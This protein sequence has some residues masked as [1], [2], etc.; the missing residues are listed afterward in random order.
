M[1]LG[2]TQDD[3][4]EL[5]RDLDIRAKKEAAEKEMEEIIKI[6]GADAIGTTFSDPEIMK[7]PENRFTFDDQ[8]KATFDVI[9]K[10]L[11]LEEVFDKYLNNE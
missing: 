3:I 11:T 5:K 6:L 1:P 10:E 2:Y 4:N 8:R 7:K 9:G